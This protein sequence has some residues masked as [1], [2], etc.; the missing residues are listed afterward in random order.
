MTD[1]VVADMLER[2]SARRDRIVVDR[3]LPRVRWR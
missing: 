3:I 1:E 2:V